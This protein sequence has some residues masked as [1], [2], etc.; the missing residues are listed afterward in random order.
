MVNPLK[1]AKS[2]GC[3][4]E[5]IDDETKFQR[6]DEILEMYK[7]ERGNLICS[8]YVAQNI[9]GYLP[10]KVIKHVAKFLS[11]PV[12]EV[13]GVASFYSFFSKFPKGKNTIKVC[14]GTACYVR[15]SK[16]ILEKLKKELGI[17]VGETTEDKQFSLEIVRCVGACALAPVIV[18]NDKTHKRVKVNKLKA[19]LDSY[20]EIEEISNEN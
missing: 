11:C 17:K 13:Q 8:L 4:C 6:L 12:V 20:R 18:I 15:G 16:L 2:R 19:I 9:F 7:D 14:L 3:D 5:K 10:S 1:V